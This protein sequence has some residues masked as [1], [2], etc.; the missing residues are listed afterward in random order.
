MKVTLKD[1]YQILDG[2]Q[3][4]MLEFEFGQRFQSMTRDLNHKEAIAIC[5]LESIYQLLKNK[6]LI[7]EN[8]DIE[9]VRVDSSPPED[10]Y[11]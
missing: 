11:L 10:D 2:A 4:K 8:L 6:N 1:L 3:Y 5:Y 9:Y 7:N